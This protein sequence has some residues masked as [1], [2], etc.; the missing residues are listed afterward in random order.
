[1][2]VPEIPDGDVP[3]QFD[4]LVFVVHGIGAACD[5]KFQSVVGATTTMRQMVNEMSERHFSYAHMAGK[6]SRIEFLPVNW[7][8]TLHGEDTGTDQVWSLTQFYSVDFSQSRIG[9]NE[10]V[11]YKRTI[12]VCVSCC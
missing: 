11:F 10:R 6:A 7:H 1:M 5:M 8:A 9:V 12:K 2:C 3:G 4:H